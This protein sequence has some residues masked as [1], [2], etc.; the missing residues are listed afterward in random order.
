MKIKNRSAAMFWEISKTFCDTFSP[1]L[2]NFQLK[3]MFRLKKY[4]AI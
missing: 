1:S 3:N 4:V 2:R